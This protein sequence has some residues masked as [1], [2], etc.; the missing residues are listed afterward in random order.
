[1]MTYLDWAATSPPDM[2]AL[3][4]AVRVA[5]EAFGNPSSRH[6]LGQEARLRLE[7]A[8]ARLAAAIGA[9]AAG[10]AAG[11]AAVPAMGHLV[12]TGGGT[13]AD[14]IPLLAVLRSAL[15]ARRD[16]SIKRLHIVTTEIEHAAVYEEAQLLKSLGLG[17]SFVAPEA[18][19]RVDPQKIAAAVEKDSALVSVMAVNNETGAIQD[20]AGIGAAIAQAASAFGRP[21]PRFHSDAV[22]ALGKVEL[23]LGA[24][25][26]GSAAFSAHKIRGPRGV[27]ALWTASPLEPLVLGGGQEGALRPGTESLQGAWA[28]A[29]AAESARSGF[30]QRADWARRLEARLLGGLS[31]IPGALALPQGRA[32]GDGRYSPYILS[33]A[34]PGL[35]G[36]VLARA[37]SD[38]GVAVS[39][40]SACSANSKSR[41]RRVLRAMGIGEELSLSAI[42]VSTGELTTEADIDAFLEAASGAYRKLKT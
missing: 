20:L 25:G 4:E 31:S 26:L 23:S 6:A 30:A 5:A 13:E 32:A 33:V 16:G 17:L 24:S 37:L 36:E 22:Q 3:A 11:T 39:T 28:F 34:F 40:G 42:R 14:H 29:S 21:P 1:M 18:D 19:G 2:D 27:G 9:P 10:T 35:S 15:N 12:F 8:R 38:E 7:E 41:G